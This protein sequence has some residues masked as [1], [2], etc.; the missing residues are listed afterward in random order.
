MKKTLI[1]A[2]L[3]L[4]LMVSCDNGSG[5][6]PLEYC[7]QEVIDENYSDYVEKDYSFSYSYKE[8]YFLGNS[9][10]D[11]WHQTPNVKSVYRY[12]ISFYLDFID[13][14]D[15]YYCGIAFNSGK[16]ERYSAKEIVIVDC[17][18]IYSTK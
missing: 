10:E 8:I 7:C 17:D 3:P 5:K 16:K 12:E 1:L 15:V 11:E 14:I 2:A 9:S 6:T 18:W 13:S 4:L